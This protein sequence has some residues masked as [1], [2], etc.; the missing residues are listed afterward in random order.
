MSL[1]RV[2]RWQGRPNGVTFKVRELALIRSVATRMTSWGVSPNL[3]QKRLRP[4]FLAVAGLAVLIAAGDRAAARGGASERAT[5][6]I[7][8]RSAGDPVMAIV[9]LRSQRITVYDAKG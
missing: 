5:E 8:S 4:A 9:S 7:Q 2:P 3:R 1:R 6:S